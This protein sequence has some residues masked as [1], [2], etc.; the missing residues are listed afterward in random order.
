MSRPFLAL[1]GLI[2]AAMVALTATAT[3]APPSNDDFAA[4]TVI[5]SL[6]FGDSGDLAEASVEP[7]EPQTCAHLSQTVWYSITP[8]TD[9]TV[10]AD[11]SGSSTLNTEIDFYREDGSGLGG[12]TVLDCGS[13]GSSVDMPLEAG[14]TYY[15]GAGNALGYGGTLQVN[16]RVVPMPD[17]SAGAAP[18]ASTPFSDPA[19][20]TDVDVNGT[21]LLAGQPIFPIVLAK[22]PNLGGTT[23]SGTDALDEVV[24]AGV[25][26]FKV[27]P[28]GPAELPYS[29]TTWT[30]AAI[31][32]AKAWDAAALSRGVHTWVNLDTLSR[33]TPGTARE[34]LLRK[35][36]TTLKNDP[37]GRGIGM[38]KGADEPW[39]GHY[40]PSI[41]QFPYCLVTGRGDSSCC[42]GQEPLDGD[43]RWVTIEAPRGTAPDL[44][45]YSAVTD[46]HGVDIYPVSLRATDPDLHQVG[47]WT[48]TIESITPNHSV[49]TTLQICFSGSYNRPTGKY[50]LPTR[51]Q[52]RYMIY[53]AIINGARG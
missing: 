31:E 8:A 22:P 17:D 45:P 19:S 25:N 44:A 2:A 9:E 7:G 48:R 20:R 16:V 51:T 40:S 4:A 41:L 10:H 13:Y 46:T 6:P 29:W 14:K 27:G 43:H 18:V 53:D 35:V 1:I 3:A 42:A 23:P 15:I 24:G 21:F 33:A 30:D 47:S 26:M 34:A 38:W 32:N 49:W 5:A 28:P 12:L 11:A 50:I 39:W 36:V 37:S 52:E